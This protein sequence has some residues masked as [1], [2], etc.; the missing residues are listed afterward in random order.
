LVFVLVSAF[1][2]VE[3]ASICIHAIVL[4]AATTLAIVVSF[5]ASA[6][7]AI[8]DFHGNITPY[9]LTPIFVHAAIATA[10]TI[11]TIFQ[12]IVCKHAPASIAKAT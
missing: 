6:Y 7:E 8:T 1:Y 5:G 10:G 2:A 9:R 11:L 3:L 4:F 12:H